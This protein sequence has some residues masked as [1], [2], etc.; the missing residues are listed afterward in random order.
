MTIVPGVLRPS[1]APRWVKC[2][3]SFRLEQMFPP[4]ADGPEAREGTAGH[5]YVT[6]AIQGRVHPVGAL[7][8]NGHPIDAD[9]I[10]EGQIFL[11]HVAKILARCGP[12]AS[13]RVE[14]KL[15]MSR[16]I[17]RDC[18]G[19]PD[20][21]IVDAAN[22][23][24]YV[25]DYKYGHEFVE[26]F[27]NEQFVCYGAGVFQG[28]EMTSD[29]FKGWRVVMTVVQ[30]RCFTTEQ[31]VRSW[32]LTGA[33][34]WDHIKRVATAAQ[35]AKNPDA[36]AVT[37]AWCGHCDGRHACELFSKVTGR[38][39]DMAGHSTPQN[40]TPAA[41]AREL[42]AVETALKRL[43]ARHTG[44][45]AVIEGTLRTGQAVPIWMLGPG[46]TREV[47]TKPVEEVAALG[48]MMGVN[49]RKP[50]VLTPAQARDA[51]I[52]DTVIKAYS[53]RPSGALKLVR[54]DDTAVNKVFGK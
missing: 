35:V 3:H 18:E 40:I 32:E 6:E 17:H 20:I 21:Y 45:V 49:L 15:T 26:V 41:M 50:T 9:M 36:I 34:L 28:Y 7:A 51:G 54:I 11:D 2:G 33:Q 39:M 24:L 31:K 19:T 48:D 42:L 37:G 46:Q 25:I 10:K 8:P 44:L 4:D 1:S 47:W 14:T 22:R 43:K 27:Q 38:A 16:L 12:G 5:Y 23:T 53:E 13:V 52:D 30:P 29:D